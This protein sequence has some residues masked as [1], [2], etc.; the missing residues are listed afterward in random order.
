MSSSAPLSRLTK[1]LYGS[2]DIGFSLTSTILGAYFALF[3]TDV[4][5]ITPGVAAIAIFIGRTWDY[6]NDPLIGHLS[7]RT[8]TRWGR[9]RPFLLFGP[10]PFALAFTMLWY[11]PPW[12]HTLFLAIYY[13]VA[14]A[15][16]DVA[17]TF[18]YMPYFA[19][20]PELT[21]D[22]DERTALTSYRMFFSIFGSLVAFT[23]PLM[24]IG[25]FNPENAPRVLTM[26]AL[27]GM[28]SALPL[29][30]TF[31]GTKER[32]VYLE[33][34]PPRLVQSL[35]AALRNRPFIF[36]MII[37]LLTWVTVDTI[38]AT[39]LYFIKYIVQQEAHSDTIMATI[40][41]TAILALPFWE[42]A[43]RHWDKR[44]AYAGGIAFWALVQLML[45]TLTPATPLPVLLF[46][47]FL[48]GIGV[49][50]AHVIPWSIIPDAVEWDEWHTGERHE[51]MFYSLITLMQKIASS[52]AVP[53]VL[54][55]LEFT[56]YIPNAAQ[57]PAS[58]LLGIRMA[59]GP[60]PALLLCGGIIFALSYPLSRTQHTQIVRE[61]EARRAMSRTEMELR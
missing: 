20:T 35:R 41:I 60:L 40:F 46:L 52:A 22:Y 49:G 32:E 17:A 5:G 30:L 21:S 51:G 39:L 45:I 23:V 15:L 38:Q 53:L 56:G 4:V 55:L 29:W 37:F 10:L 14:Y 12:E 19:L 47:C 7:D 50:A 54:L 36:G 16:F 11:R 13:A 58:A 8:R 31:A 26:G 33:Q 42:W 1:I 34:A 59:I 25:S 18:V 2:G 6:I 28:I 43:S 9:R 57:Q 27:F 3:L 44:R 48:A 61:L 24:I